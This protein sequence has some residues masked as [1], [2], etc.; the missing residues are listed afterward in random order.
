MRPN[1]PQQRDIMNLVL[2]VE[3]KATGL[4]SVAWPVTWAELYQASKR[5]ENAEAEI[6]LAACDDT[7]DD[8]INENITQH[9]DV[10]DLI[11]P[12]NGIN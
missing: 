6:N 4:E 1:R 7:Y 12:D 2:D 9:L 8:V 11:G 10:D 3:S 5:K